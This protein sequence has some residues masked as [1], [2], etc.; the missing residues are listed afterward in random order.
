[1]NVDFF[2][3]SAGNPSPLVSLGDALST[4]EKVLVKVKVV[5]MMLGVWVGVVQVAPPLLLC[6]VYPS[7][8]QRGRW[9]VPVPNPPG[10]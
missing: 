7:A 3:V 8:E 2:H 9:Y 5:D 6:L 1:M 10:P 4:R